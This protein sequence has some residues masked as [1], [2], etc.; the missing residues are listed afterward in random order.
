MNRM[1]SLRFEL[2]HPGYYVAEADGDMGITQL[3]E[4]NQNPYVPIFGDTS[5]LTAAS[6]VAPGA[7][8]LSSEPIWFGDFSERL[9]VNRRSADPDFWAELWEVCPDLRVA[10]R[11]IRPGTP[12]VVATVNVGS[13]A[14][15]RSFADGLFP[16]DRHGTW[17][18]F[19]LLAVEG[20]PSCLD[21]IARGVPR[22]KPAQG[23]E[24]LR[25]KRRE[26]YRHLKWRDRAAFLDLAVV[27]PG[28]Y[29]GDGR[30]A[31][32]DRFRRDLCAAYR[33]TKPGGTV[34]AYFDPELLDVRC[35]YSHGNYGGYSYR[36]G[37]EATEAAVSALTSAV[38]AMG[39]APIACAG[40]VAMSVRKPTW[41][42][43][44]DG[45]AIMVANRPPNCGVEDLL[46]SWLGYPPV[47]FP[48]RQ[49]REILAESFCWS[50]YVEDDA[51]DVRHVSHI[52][53]N[54]ADL[55][56]ECVEYAQENVWEEIPYGNYSYF[57]FAPFL[58]ALDRHQALRLANAGSGVRPAP[59]LPA[60]RRA[61]IAQFFYDVVDQIYSE[62]AWEAEEAVAQDFPDHALFPSFVE[63]Q[64]AVRQGYSRGGGH[65]SFKQMLERGGVFSYCRTLKI[66]HL[67]F[68]GWLKEVRLPL[69][70]AVG[71]YDDRRV[72]ED[73]E[74]IAEDLYDAALGRVALEMCRTAAGAAGEEAL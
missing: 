2:G 36:F 33:A 23:M 46:E 18:G 51:G 71:L 20:E 5:R 41:I 66:F 40:G 64:A 43:D 48:S 44:S 55:Y 70:A 29:P 24:N 28:I 73:L 15:V 72:G 49:V 35:E 54:F 59:M 31:H 50:S 9:Q 11:D 62:L 57:S 60:V 63:E 38:V 1:T 6:P 19:E 3:V 68:L 53:E 13:P 12:R 10:H 58:L 56:Q 42:S 7:L 22:M 32:V 47:S 21:A 8:C 17:E 67:D 45:R 30:A 61:A 25:R 37:S 26:D 52:G 16:A 14:A 34:I 65:K 39:F 69:D 74:A 27:F 4:V